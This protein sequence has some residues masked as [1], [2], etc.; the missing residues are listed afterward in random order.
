MSGGIVGYLGPEGGGRTNFEDV[1]S[2]D[3]V[4]GV[5]VKDCH[6]LLST[7]CLSLCEK[8]CAEVAELMY[9]E[10]F[11]GVGGGDCGGGRLVV[12]PEWKVRVYE[13]VYCRLR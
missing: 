9:N 11:G 5:R 12:E 8:G 13:Y 4:V 10:M 1:R 6:F 2:G 3:R 7:G